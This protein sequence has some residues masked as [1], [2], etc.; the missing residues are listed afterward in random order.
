MGYAPG[1]VRWTTTPLAGP[2]DDT[3][4]EPDNIWC[5]EDTDGM[6][7]ATSVG[8]KYPTGREDSF[9]YP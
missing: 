8:S 1:T 9:L 6:D 3:T 4:N 2:I 5:W 7:S